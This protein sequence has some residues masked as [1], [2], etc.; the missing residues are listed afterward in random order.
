MVPNKH[1]VYSPDDSWHFQLQDSKSL[2][3]LLFTV[4]FVCIIKNVFIY[5]LTKYISFIFLF[6]LV[7]LTK[8]V[9]M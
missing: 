8:D 6:N 2:K 1:K 7:S 5:Y 9:S 4:E 3:N